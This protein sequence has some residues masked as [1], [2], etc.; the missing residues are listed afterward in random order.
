MVKRCG[1]VL[2]NLARYLS[3]RFCSISSPIQHQFGRALGRH[4]YEAKSSVFK[5]IGLQRRRSATN[6]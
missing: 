5:R 1:G 3:V 2:M 4:M 6:E